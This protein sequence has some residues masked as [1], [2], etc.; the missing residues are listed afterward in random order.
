MNKITL[1]QLMQYYDTAQDVRELVQVVFE[2]QDWD[3]AEELY[4][5]SEFLKPLYG[6]T[7][8]ALRCEESY[9]EGLPV[10]RVMIEKGENEYGYRLEKKADLPEVL[11]S[12]LQLCCN[13][14]YCPGRHG[15]GRRSGDRAYYGRGN[16]YRLYHQRRAG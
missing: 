10:L 15:A 11:G 5:D 3:E 1:G 7:V 8:T 14:D 16:G 12:G 4:A 6:Y 2:G 13:A 9:E